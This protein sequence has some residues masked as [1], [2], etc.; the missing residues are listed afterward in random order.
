MKL[1]ETRIRL[2][3]TD[4][5]RLRRAAAYGQMSMAELVRR[6]TLDR[7]AAFEDEFE[8][9]IIEQRTDTPPHPA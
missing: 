5:E 7:V 8:R 6:A 1:H 3:T 4:H 9:R 2:T